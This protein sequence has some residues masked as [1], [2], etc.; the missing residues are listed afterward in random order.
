GR[1]EDAAEHANG[2]ALAAAVGAEEGED[3]AAADAEAEV[4]D[5]HEVAEAPGEMPHLDRRFVLGGH[6]PSRFTKRLALTQKTSSPNA[7]RASA[8]GQSASS[9]TPFRMIPRKIWRK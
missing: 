5:R 6:Q 1:G 2:G 4:I 9:P 8:W 3:L 7:D